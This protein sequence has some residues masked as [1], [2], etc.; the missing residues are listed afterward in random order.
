MKTYKLTAVAMLSCV[1]AILQISNGVIG[2]PTP[3]GMTVDLVG[4]PILLCFLLF[5]LD[6]AMYAALL[7]TLIITLIAPTS[8]I[9]AIMKFTATVPMFLVPAFY[10][11][12][13][14]KNFDLGK[15]LINVFFALFI[16][17]MLFI[18]SINSNLVGQSYI[19]PTSSVKYSVPV[20]SYLSPAE[21]TFTASDLLLGLLP[22]ATIA[23]FSFIVLHFWGRY[24]KDTSPLIFS[25]A[26]ATFIVAF[27]GILVRGVAM[28]IANYYFAGPIFFNTSPSDLMAAVPW[29]LIFLW[30]AF[31]GII[32]VALAWT[33]AFKFRFIERYMKW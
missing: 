23:V 28:V 11:L 17:M 14:K 16:S 12:S 10:L 9:G 1:A 15:L 8:W 2:I 33:L 27:L 32:E 30:N 26:N 19:T 24:S 18:L 4:V 5:G 22:V 13:V 31:Q 20:L 7:T 6:A 21:V 25:N 29:Y 3:F